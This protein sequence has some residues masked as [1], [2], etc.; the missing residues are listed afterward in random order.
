MA[1]E[2]RNLQ[3]PEEVVVPQA[4][5]EVPSDS[6]PTP[7]SG[8][9][10]ANNLERSQGPDE[11]EKLRRDYSASSKEARLQKEEKERAIERAEKLQQELLATV[12]R[13]RDTFQDYL[14]SKG[15]SPEEKVYYMNIYDKEIAPKRGDTTQA[16]EN[17]VQSIPSAPPVNPIR[18][19]WMSKIDQEMAA[20]YQAQK[21]AVDEFF[22]RDEN[23]NLDPVEQ[24][25]IRTL[26]EALDVKHGYSPREALEAARKR[27][28]SADE[29][30]EQGYIDGVRDSFVGGISR[31][32]SG[33][34]GSNKGSAFTLP[35]KHQAFVDAEIQRK[36]L[37]GKAA[38]DYKR[39]YALK[40]ARE[41]E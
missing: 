29:I 8:K 3:T 11:V 19:S 1:D 20:K 14:E 38:E 34:S 25:A 32:V 15:L 18:E 5:F 21:E 39:S 16:R 26:A 22:S 30:R 23:K 40:L 10:E 28:L 33:A 9:D 4:S 31:G 6:S 27:V 36:G 13:S 2:E 41:S 24:Q 17:L 12:T 7:E 35:K 37:T